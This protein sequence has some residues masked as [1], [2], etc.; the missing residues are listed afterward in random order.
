MAVVLPER[1]HGRALGSDGGDPA[2]GERVQVAGGTELTP[3]KVWELK[4]TCVG[5]PDGTV[6]RRPP[7]S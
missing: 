7:R 5:R 6:G 4:A 1:G 2:R 3:R